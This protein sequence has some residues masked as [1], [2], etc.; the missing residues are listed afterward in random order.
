M[1]KQ[2][3]HI[4]HINALGALNRNVWN[5][6]LRYRGLYVTNRWSCYCIFQ[7]IYIPT[8]A[9]YDCLIK[10]WYDI[11]PTVLV[12]LLIFL[13]V[14][15]TFTLLLLVFF[16]GCSGSYLQHTRSSLQRVGSSPLTRDKTWA[17]LCQ[18]HRVLTTGATREVS[19]LCILK[20]CYEAF[21]TL[22]L[23]HFEDVNHLSMFLPLF[24]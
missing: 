6:A 20:L 2:F 24:Q 12:D 8:D 1:S 4:F 11:S 5:P 13:I 10:Y 22:E 9:F 17:P 14:L 3:G 18:K 7:I 21:T 16:F 19:A 15:A 23:S